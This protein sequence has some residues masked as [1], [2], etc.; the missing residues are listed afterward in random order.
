MPADL[1]IVLVPGLG[2]SV[3]NHLP[4][5]PTLWRHGSVLVANQTRDETIAAMARRV[6]DE[7]PERFS[8]IG[9]S[10]GGYIVLEMIRQQPQRIVRLA[11]LNTSARP[12][13]AEATRLRNERVAETRAGRYAEV[14]S[15]SFPQSVH[16]DRVDDPHLREM[17]RLTGE[18]SGPDA[19]IRQQTA[20]IARIDS[21]PFLKDIRVPTLVLSGDKDLLISNEFS[22]EMAEMI[23]GASL[24]I[25]P[26]CGHLAPVEQP[27]AVSAALDAWLRRPL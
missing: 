3:R 10:L 15:A 22:K 11:L 21:R 4:I 5:L 14:R 13:T 9:H 25:V 2:S 7:A 1:P 12:D 24:V 23:P 20:I 6:L 17:S 26:D 19:Y 18:D 16:P 27:E 8:L